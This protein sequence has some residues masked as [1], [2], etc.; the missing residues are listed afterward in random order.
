MS[1]SSLL[2]TYLNSQAEYINDVDGDKKVWSILDGRIKEF[3]VSNF[4]KRYTKYNGN[5]LPLLMSKLTDD[6]IL[7]YDGKYIFI[8]D[9]YPDVN[10]AIENMEVFDTP[11]EVWEKVIRPDIEAYYSDN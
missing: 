10:W 6:Y 11:Q 9:S 5:L 8:H 1:L 3:V 7:E 4:N 2:I